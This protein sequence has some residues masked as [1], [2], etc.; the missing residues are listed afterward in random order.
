MDSIRQFGS[1]PAENM[2]QWLHLCI[3]LRQYGVMQRKQEK[4]RAAAVQQLGLSIVQEENETTT[5]TLREVMTNT[6]TRPLAAM[7][8]SKPVVERKDDPM[9]PEPT[10]Q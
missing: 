2:F 1:K 4:E 10:I 3:I 9:L 5:E 8:N 7:P 6:I